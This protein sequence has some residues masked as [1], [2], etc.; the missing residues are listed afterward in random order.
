M[1]CGSNSATT[2]SLNR[3]RNDDF[4]SVPGASG[5]RRQIENVRNRFNRA[6]IGV[7]RILLAM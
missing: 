2:D 4:A 7:L 1:N 3:V 6:L 5:A